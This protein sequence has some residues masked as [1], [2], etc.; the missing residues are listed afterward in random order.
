M[1]ASVWV[2]E[3]VADG[4]AIGSLAPGATEIVARAP[5]RPQRRM[6]VPSGVW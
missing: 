3:E 4:L 2:S 6:V 1:Q 5:N